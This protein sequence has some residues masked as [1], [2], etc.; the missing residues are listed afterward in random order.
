MS[1]AEGDDDSGSEDGSSGDGSSS[2]SNLQLLVDS[3]VEEAVVLGKDKDEDSDISELGLELKEADGLM[4]AWVKLDC[5]GEYTLGQVV[6]IH[7]ITGSLESLYL[8]KYVD[9]S[10]EHLSKHQV[11]THV[12]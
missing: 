4:E 10:F 9:G 11:L 12:R 7:A 5:S 8:V 3:S 1:G 2:V 6:D